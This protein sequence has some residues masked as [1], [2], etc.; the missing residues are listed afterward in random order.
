MKTLTFKI[1]RV[2]IFLI[3][4]FKFNQN[5]NEVVI[6]TLDLEVVKLPF[7]W[8]FFFKREVEENY[9]FTQWSL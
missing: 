2:E 1:R 9:W 4:L 7:L 6:E 5:Q 3:S 8:Y